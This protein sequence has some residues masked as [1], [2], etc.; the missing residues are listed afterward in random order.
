MT[1]GL[2]GRTQPR[3]AWPFRFKRCGRWLQ[4]LNIQPWRQGRAR[5]SPTL[6][7]PACAG[8]PEWV[9]DIKGGNY[10]EM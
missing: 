1:L 5:L 3:H 2:W 10:D 8:L 6:W 7:S 9:L 4:T